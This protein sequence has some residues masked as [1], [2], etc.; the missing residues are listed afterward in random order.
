MVRCCLLIL[1]LCL[2]FRASAV[3]V[4]TLEAMLPAGS[5]LALSVYNIDSKQQMV[6]LDDQILLPPA[7]TQKVV[8]ALASALYLPKDFTFTT[9]AYRSGKDVIFSFSGD[10]T[11]TRKNIQSLLKDIKTAGVTRING[12]VWLDGSIFTGYERAVGWP[13][14]ILGVCYSAPSTSIALERNCVQGSIYSEKGK[15]TTRVFVP[16]HQPISVTTDALAVTKDEMKTTH[17][18]LE[19][20]YENNNSYKLTGC[21][22]H[23]SKPLPLKF[24]V[25]NPEKYMRDVLS[26]ELKKARIGLTGQIRIGNPIS[27]APKQR[28]ATH[29]SAPRDILLKKMLKRSDN[30]I[31]D[32]LLKTLGHQY[33]NQPGSFSNGAAAVKAIMQER[34]NI[35][36]THALIVDGS[37]LSRN[38]RMSAKQLMDVIHYTYSHQDLGVLAML[39]VSGVDGTL[40]Y[41]S[42]VRNAPLKQRLK[43]KSGSLYGS[44][45]LAGVIRNDKGQDVLVVQLVTNYHIPKTDERPATLASPITQFEREL[46]QALLTSS[47]TTR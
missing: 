28:I 22:P 27:N 39:P 10:P 4:N 36:L 19:L 43:A 16:E 15:T 30:L 1:S 45:N 9:H 38:N 7:S 12:D 18:D 41:R 17:C 8:T 13:W 24:A 5:Q 35:D 40:K 42:S 25:Q 44:Y 11:L 32:N 2:S 33:F 37:G 34:A 21:L 23:R 46:Y 20:H 29:T 14:D 3:P 31:A 47:L 26:A 6:A